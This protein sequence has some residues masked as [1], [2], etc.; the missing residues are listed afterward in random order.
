MELL[1]QQHAD[2]LTT[3]AGIMVAQMIVCC[4]PMVNELLCG[5]LA[6]RGPFLFTTRLLF[7]LWSFVNEEKWSHL[8]LAVGNMH[9][10]IALKIYK[11]ETCKCQALSFGGGR[12]KRLAPFCI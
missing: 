3:N 5:S 12:A 8:T 1:N 7:Q 2:M 6:V 10:P 9:C 4:R 11:L